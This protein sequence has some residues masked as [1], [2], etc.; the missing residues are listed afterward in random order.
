MSQYEPAME[1]KA[2]YQLFGVE[3]REGWAGLYQPLI[4]RCLNERVRILQVKQKLG[5]LGF[6]VDGGCRA[7]L[8]AIIEAECRS[9]QI[10][11]LCGEPGRQRAGDYILTLCDRH[12]TGGTRAAEALSRRGP[13]AGG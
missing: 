5:R 1:P 11:E 12:A 13:D 4:E 8:E 10:C 6:Y 3:C 2:P 9:V 7:L